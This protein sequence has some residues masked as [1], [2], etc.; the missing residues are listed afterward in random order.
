[1]KVTPVRTDVRLDPV[2]HERVKEIA[3][4]EKRS[5][6]G[7]IEYFIARGIDE[8]DSGITSRAPEE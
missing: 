1:M 4:R 3:A 2:L 8:Y 5:L 7:Q 6:N